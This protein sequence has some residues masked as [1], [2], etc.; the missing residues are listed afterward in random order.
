MVPCW[1]VAFTV[2][3]EHGSRASYR[4]GP[5]H[6]QAHAHDPQAMQ[7]QMMKDVKK[8]AMMAMIFGMIGSLVT[9][10]ISGFVRRN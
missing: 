1:R 7:D 5:E 3:H 8:Q 10:I 9:S 6:G 2:Q 4:P